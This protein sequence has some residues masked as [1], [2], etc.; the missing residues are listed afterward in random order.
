MSLALRRVFAGAM[1]LLAAGCAQLFGIDA[2]DEVP[3]RDAAAEAADA[4]TTP[5]GASPA[6]DA[7]DAGD[8]LDATTETS[9]PETSVDAHP[10]PADSSPGPA[11][12]A[13][14][15]AADAPPPVGSLQLGP[16]THDYGNVGVGQAVDQLFTVTVTGTV[17]GLSLAGLSGPFALNASK[18]TCV[19]GGTMTDA[20]CAIGVDFQP[21]AAGTQTATLTVGATG[22]STASAHLTG[23]G[24]VPSGSLVVAGA[25][26]VWGV[27]AGGWAIVSAGGTT[28][29]LDTASAAT[30]T[31]PVSA[32]STVLVFGAYAL[33]WDTPAAGQATAPLSVWSD[34]TKQAAS[35]PASYPGLGTATTGWPTD[36][37]VFEVPNSA[38]KGADIVVAN[39]T[40]PTAT[41][42]L[43]GQVNL[44]GASGGP[45]T[46]FGVGSHFVATSQHIFFGT[47]LINA[48]GG[49]NQW[50]YGYDQGLA[51]VLSVAPC[52]W[53]IASPPG[54]KDRVFYTT[55]GNP[56]LAY[57][58]DF[59]ST[60]T[61]NTPSFGTCSGRLS[62][63][64]QTLALVGSTGSTQGAL[65]VAVS[66]TAPPFGSATPIDSVGFGG[67]WAVS[68]DG[69]WALF[70]AGF[71]QDAQGGEASDVGIAPLTAGQPT[72]P[73]APSP[74][75]PLG[76]SPDSKFVG[77]LG[78]YDVTTGLG[79]LYAA[80][81]GSAGAK[82]AGS[83]SLQAPVTTAGAS[84]FAFNG[85]VQGATGDIFYIGATNLSSTLVA[86][87]A[88]A[89]FAATAGAGATSSKIV[90]GKTSSIRASPAS[91]CSPSREGRSRRYFARV[92]STRRS[93]AEPASSVPSASRAPRELFSMRPAWIPWSVRY[94]LTLV[95][96][97][98][99]SARL[100]SLV[101]RGSAR[102]TT[103]MFS[104]FIGPVVKHLATASSAS[105]SAAVSLES[106]KLNWEESPS[107]SSH[108]CMMSDDTEIEG[109]RYDDPGLL[110]DDRRRRRRRRRG[111]R[112]RLDDDRGRLH[113]DGRRR[114]GR[115][116]A[117]L[118]ELR[119]GS[120]RDAC[121]RTRRCRSGPSGPR[122]RTC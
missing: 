105:R 37:V 20:T 48:V 94:A 51:S 55:G 36:K 112:R 9:T 21:T 17:Q 30:Q 54:L 46:C 24:A 15:D 77:Y 98:W 47:C 26:D 119:L 121:G 80:F 106:S 4:A 60:T 87:H 109:L 103:F 84:G 67:I 85:N 81:T 91:T 59:S 79:D 68:P 11:D 73:L 19:A 108:A 76:F 65:D 63:D 78:N 116:D 39:V 28:F 69:R 2:P 82:L 71:V 13:D 122:A 3:A 114:L 45:S 7:E 83:S 64:G 107:L 90:F 96:R 33:I 1:V 120:R 16:S 35:G 5:D 31:I 89:R 102:P 8:A 62:P 40:S 52:G 22:A 41:T 49:V 25:G 72:V 14:A 27:T 32:P 29:A 57:V 113:D 56:S 66:S 75:R 6:G 34:A 93:F 88:H 23:N 38:G 101:P 100:Y 86:P 99:P 58:D 53:D 95:A 117:H 104:P 115:S 18:T 10:P 42:A 92:M 74:A 12:A 50:L 118:D 43:V 111:R 61:W 110:L 97:R 70:H 44:P